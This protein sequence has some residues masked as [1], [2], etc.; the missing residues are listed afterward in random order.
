MHGEVGKSD[1]LHFACFDGFFHGFPAGNVVAVRL[2]EQQEI[3]V[4][5]AE[6]FER[7]VDISAA[8]LVG[9]ALRD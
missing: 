1:G 3:R 5:H 4:I 6:S 2:V 8:L 7:G 9:V